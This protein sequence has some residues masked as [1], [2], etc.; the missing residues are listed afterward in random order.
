MKDIDDVSLVNAFESGL[1]SQVREAARK[2]TSKAI[3][4]LATLM[5]GKKVPPNVRRQASMDLLSQAWGRPDARED[6]GG[7]KTANNLTIVINRLYDGGQDTIDIDITAAKEI[8]ANV[9]AIKEIPH[10]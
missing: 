7:Q 8:A 9:D 10:E 2:H 5:N 1:N 3:S 4:T 6:T